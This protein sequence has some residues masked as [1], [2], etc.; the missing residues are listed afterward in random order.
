[1]T[2]PNENEKW[3]IIEA[4]YKADIDRLNQQL[5]FCLIFRGWAITIFVAVLTAQIVYHVPSASIAGVIA[6]LV[7]FY[8]ECM[9]DARRIIFLKRI[10]DIEKNFFSRKVADLK[11]ELN[12]D[13]SVMEKSFPLLADKELTY[14]TRKSLLLAIKSPVRL[15]TYA[16][17]IIA[18]I[19]SVIIK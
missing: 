1:M 12:I 8:S 19:V 3:H 6:I 15:M 11:T 9:Y 4:V 2:A 10:N 17:M 5:H 13:N 7:F 16:V 14:D 18:L